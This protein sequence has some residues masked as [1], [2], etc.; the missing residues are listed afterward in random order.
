MSGLGHSWTVRSVLPTWSDRFRSR[1]ILI[2]RVPLT[3]RWSLPVLNLLFT[4]T[5]LNMR[6]LSILKSISLFALQNFYK[7]RF[8][9]RTAPA[10]RESWLAFGPLVS[11]PS[12]MRSQTRFATSLSYFFIK[13]SHDSGGVSLGGAMDFVTSP[14]PSTSS[15]ELLEVSAYNC[16]TLREYLSVTQYEVLYPSGNRRIIFLLPILPTVSTALFIKNSGCF[17]H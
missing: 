4:E 10:C 7:R 1:L 9:Y 6:F 15:S 13:V 8:L 17:I 5:F 12:A 2:I 16:M 11:T 3:I 14:K